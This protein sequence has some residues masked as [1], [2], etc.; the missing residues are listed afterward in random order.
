MGVVAV[1]GVLL[2]SVVLVGSVVVVVGPLLVLVAVVVVVMWICLGNR[3]YRWPVPFGGAL[4]PLLW[5][6]TS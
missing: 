6:V 4:Y 5:L 3:V 2:M 1:L